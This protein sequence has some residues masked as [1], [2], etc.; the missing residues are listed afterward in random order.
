MKLKL[1][2][3]ITISL[4]GIYNNPTYEYG[5]TTTLQ[6]KVMKVVY[7]TNGGSSY[8]TY[9]L[10]LNNSINVNS[11]DEWEGHNNVREIHLNIINN[12]IEMYN[13]QTIKVEGMI[14]HALTAHHKRDICMKV[15]KIKN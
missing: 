11:N 9:I 14:F 1:F 3:L 2:F 4:L 12:E 6:G 7:E 8:S 10:R 5:D 15:E 13:D